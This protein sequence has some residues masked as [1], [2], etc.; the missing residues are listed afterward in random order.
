MVKSLASPWDC[1]HE[2]VSSHP[3][4]ELILLAV[5]LVCPL[6]C[7]EWQLKIDRDYTALQSVTTCGGV[8]LIIHSR[9]MWRLSHIL[10]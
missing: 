9:R 7:R 2:R 5:V 10:S 6:A 1:F 3:K 4:K 8:E